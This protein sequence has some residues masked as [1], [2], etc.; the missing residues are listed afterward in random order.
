MKLTRAHFIR[1]LPVTILAVLVWI[2]VTELLDIS[3]VIL[4]IGCALIGFLSRQWYDRRHK[5]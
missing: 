2:A 3:V 5:Q 1:S 4:F